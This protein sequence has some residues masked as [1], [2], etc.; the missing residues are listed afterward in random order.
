M[1]LCIA[2]HHNAFALRDIISKCF[3]DAGMRL[4]KVLLPCLEK[5]RM[6]PCKYALEESETTGE[7][8]FS[9]EHVHQYAVRVIMISYLALM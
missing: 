7:A 4:H 2:L 1:L 3:C 9:I 8:V 5:R 6:I